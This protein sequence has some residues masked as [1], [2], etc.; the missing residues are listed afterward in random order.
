MW[1]QIDPAGKN[2]CKQ[3]FTVILQ[4]KNPAILQGFLQLQ[5]YMRRL[6]NYLPQHGLQN[7]TIDIII[8]FHIRIQP[9]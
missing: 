3:F 4:Q 7:T 8:D 1:L 2:F 9:D 5:V 6:A